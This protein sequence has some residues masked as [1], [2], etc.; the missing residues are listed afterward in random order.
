MAEWKD[1]EIVAVRQLLTQ[2]LPAEDAPVLSFAER[3][4]NMDASFGA[5]PLP[6]GVQVEQLELGGRPAERIVPRGADLTKVLF[7]LHGG[8][9]CVGSP[10]SHRALVARMAAA[11][12]VTAL[13][14]DYRMA[15]EHPFPAA[16]DDAL[17]AYRQIVSHADPKSVIIAGDS[18]GGGLTFATAVAARDAGLPMPA[19]LVTISPWVNLTNTGKAYAVKAATDPMINE[20]NI[21]EFA[22]AY[23]GAQDRKTPLA[24]PLFADLA[25]LPPVLIQVGSEEVLLSD[26]TGIA[27]AL[28][29]ARVD[30]TLRIW[31]EMIHIWHILAFQLAAGRAA[32][33][34]AA[35]W[36]KARLG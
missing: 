15:P 21:N 36:I 10:T 22:D 28:G 35:A 20:T 6:E 29:L 26:S 16:V 7:Y 24:S 2:M 32:S 33:D 34:E 12:G 8:G 1:L 23:L 11:A 31:P 14:L 18:A 19:G 9:Y 17:A 13:V 3:R 4:P 27:E 25:G 5:A 30:V